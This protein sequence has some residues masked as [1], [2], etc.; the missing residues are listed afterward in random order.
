MSNLKKE[1]TNFMARLEQSVTDGK[2]F[3]HNRRTILEMS[4]KVLENIAVKYSNVQ[5]EV[6]KIMG[7]KILDYEGRNI[8]YEGVEQGRNEGIAVGRSETL[9]AALNSCVQAAWLM[10]K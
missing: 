7:G 5:K 3:T 2:I 9:N 4:K 10:N 8:F 6:K 1:Y